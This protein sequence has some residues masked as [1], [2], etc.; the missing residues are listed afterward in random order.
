MKCPI[1]PSR[2]FGVR[3]ISKKSQSWSIDIILA[4]V[5]FMGAFFLFYSI[6]SDDPA[7]SAKNLK[8]DASLVIRQVSSEGL[9]VN[10]LDRQQVNISKLN[11]LKNLT[12]AELK[13][14]LRVEGDFCIYME[15]DKGYVVIV[16]NSYKGIGSPKINISNTPCNETIN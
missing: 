1:A 4:V 6:L 13:S 5:L 3:L 11:E 2:L 12:Y 16:N 8:N 15:D 14:M 10:I 9:P 7:A